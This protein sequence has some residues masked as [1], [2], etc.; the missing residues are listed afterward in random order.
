[1][2]GIEFRNEEGGVMG[3]VAP[4]TRG[5]WNAGLTDTDAGM[6]VPGSLR[7]FPAAKKDDAVTY[8]RRIAGLKSGG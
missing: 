1:M 3:W 2:E 4:A 5:R 6:I 7:V 8:A